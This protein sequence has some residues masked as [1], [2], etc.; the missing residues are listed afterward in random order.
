MEMRGRPMAGWL[1]VGPEAI[2]TRRQL[3][4]WVERSVAYAKTL[5]AK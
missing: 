3:A 5:P 2:K 1:T 4:P